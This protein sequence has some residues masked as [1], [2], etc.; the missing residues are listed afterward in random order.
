MSLSFQDL[1]KHD[2]E[3]IVA[4]GEFGVSATLV[5]PGEDD[6]TITGL[7]GLDV[8][9][10]VSDEGGLRIIH[11]RTF[12]TSLDNEIVTAAHGQNCSSLTIDAETWQCLSRQKDFAKQIVTLRRDEKVM[13]KQGR[14][15]P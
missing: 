14:P 11:T 7:L 5:T 4:G 1:L 6:E 12:S 13:T 10:R 8:E 15:R 3:Q 9:E 2:F